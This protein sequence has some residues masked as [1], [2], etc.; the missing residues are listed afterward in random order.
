MAAV[1]DY[2]GK[3]VP[4]SKAKPEYI[5]VE[6]DFA[7][8]GGATG[9]LDLFVAGVALVVLRAYIVSLTTL[10]SGGSATLSVGKAGDLAGIVGATAIANLEAGEV[11][12]PVAADLASNVIAADAAVQM[13]IATAA[14]TAGKVRFVFEVMAL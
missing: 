5:T 13:E 14:M 12:F 4:L 6:W 2:K 7:K 8:D 9:A 11:A 1:V 3:L 10:T